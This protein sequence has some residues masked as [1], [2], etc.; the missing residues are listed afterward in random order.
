MEQL[1]RRRAGAPLAQRLDGQCARSHDQRGREPVSPTAPSAH[2]D[3]ESEPP[4][5]RRPSRGESCSL[6]LCGWFNH[7]EAELADAG[8]T[9]NTPGLSLN[10]PDEAAASPAYAFLHSKLQQHTDGLLVAEE[11]QR[12]VKHAQDQLEFTRKE[13]ALL[14]HDLVATR[15]HLRESEDVRV[16]VCVSL[17]AVCRVEV[18]LVTQCNVGIRDGTALLAMRAHAEGDGAAPSSA[19]ERHAPTGRSETRSPRVRPQPPEHD[20]AAAHDSADAA[21]PRPARA[22]G[23]SGPTYGQLEAPGVWVGTQRAG[24]AR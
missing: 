4:L 17:L 20:P 19:R 10:I 2:A 1:Y 8:V 13:Q 14:R 22:Q 15:S 18:A 7:R 16:S 24:D 6:C 11:H 3:A 23:T 9:Q 5:E 12:A 21:E